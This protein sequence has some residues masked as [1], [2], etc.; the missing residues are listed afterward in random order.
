MSNGI[1]SFRPPAPASHS[2]NS[3]IGEG[4]REERE[5]R[6]R[7][8]EEREICQCYNDSLTSILGPLPLILHSIVVQLW[9]PPKSGVVVVTVP[10]F[11]RPHFNIMLG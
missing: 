1:T 4:E 6:E 2:C 10:A 9:W 11:P 5:K 7:E 3:V 8:K